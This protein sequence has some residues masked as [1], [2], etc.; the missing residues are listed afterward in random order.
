MT[1][2]RTDEADPITLLLLVGGEGDSPVEQP[3]RQARQA[4]ARD[5]LETLLEAGVVQRAVVATD[6]AAWA[7][8]LPAVIAEAAQE[9]DLV[10]VD[11]PPLL[12]FPEPLQIAA[13]VDGVVLITVA[14]RTPRKAVAGALATLGR[15]RARTLGLVLNA[16]TSD[17]S[18]YS[19]YG[20]YG[21]YYKYYRRSSS[22][23]G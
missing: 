23:S 2:T 11:S 3:I 22:A 14:G 7:A 20:Y 1:V 6:D 13:V 19:Y 5:L 18:A 17:L 9:Y 21:K 12:G 8:G 10:V 16:V 4:A 15:V